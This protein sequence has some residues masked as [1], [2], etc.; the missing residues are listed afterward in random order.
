MLFQL[1]NTFISKDFLIPS[2]S[3]KKNQ[4]SRYSFQKVFCIICCSPLR[5]P[6]LVLELPAYLVIRA[7]TGPAWLS[8]STAVCTVVQLLL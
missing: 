8:A 7:L 4:K 2:L 1:Y 6:M 3:V 5:T